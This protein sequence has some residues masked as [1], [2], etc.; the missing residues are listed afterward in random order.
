MR[1][2]TSLTAV[3]LATAISW[4]VHAADFVPYEP[5]APAVPSYT[6]PAK[7]IADWTGFYAGVHGGLGAGSVR[8]HALGD[9]YLG[10]IGGLLEEHE[11][12]QFVGDFLNQV[13]GDENLDPAVPTQFDAHLSNRSSGFLGGVQIGYNHQVSSNFV[14]GVET[15]FS[16]TNIRAHT[17]GQARLALVPTP[18]EVDFSAR[19]E[20]DWFG[21]VRARG[22]W[23]NSDWMIYGTGG[24]AY[25]RT[26]T[27]L[28]AL[29]GSWSRQ[30]NPTGWTV[31]G[32]VEYAL[33]DSVTLKTEYLYVD[34]GKQTF[35]QDLP[36]NLGT[37][38][39]TEDHRFHTI[40]A[41]LNFQFSW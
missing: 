3:L 17:E 26:H 25:A 15:D 12:L 35:S 13:L 39:V 10:R 6:A 36:G 34:L 5:E 1:H 20:I 22:G 40:K 11:D 37:L 7:N 27:H 30:A 19:S 41:G 14:L 21:T 24:F 32:G 28:S 38:N 33:S 8:H 2:R 16:F 31:G 23:A 18:L 9:V 29:G 4:P